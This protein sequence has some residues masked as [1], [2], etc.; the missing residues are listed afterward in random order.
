MAVDLTLLERIDAQRRRDGLL[1]VAEIVDRVG[2]TNRVYDPFSLIVSRGVT[3]GRGNVF[4]PAVSL[5]A[6]ADAELTIGDENIF[7]P[8]TA[9]SAESGPLAVGSG[10]QFGEGGFTARTNRAGASIAIGDGGRYLG[11]AAVYGAS[12]L[13]SGSQ[14]LGAVTAESVV[15]E[16]GGDF[17][18]P[19]PDERAGLL[20]G[21]GPAR[22]LTVPRGRVIAGAGGFSA[23]RLQL[24]SDFHP[25]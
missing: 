19:D 16:A 5:M 13:G 15:L 21:F 8:L 24:Q 17:R 23:D 7:H 12:R 20:K 18:S 3:I 22:R 2:A 25:A 4:H 11:G 14:I 10:N 1:T 9:M 6:S